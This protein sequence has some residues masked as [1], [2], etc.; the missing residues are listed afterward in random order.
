MA[1][2]KLFRS[3]YID[4][5]FRNIKNGDWG[6]YLAEE[7]KYDDSA[8]IPNIEMKVTPAKLRIPESGKSYDFENSK[9]IFEA[10]NNLTPVQATDTRLWTYLAHVTYWKYLK[11]RRPVENQSEEKRSKYILTHW[12]ID[13]V[14]AGS[15]LR[16]DISLLWWVSYLTHDSERT[17]P[18]ELTNEAFSMLDYTRHLLPGVQGRNKTFT[19]ALLEYV[20]ENKTLF[21]RYKEAKVRFLMRKANLIAGYKVFPSLSKE[22]IKSIFN[23]Y[24]SETESTTGEV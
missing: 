1:V 6:K 20:I 3:G 17:N 5:L 22:E 13:R 10:Y 2:Q 18:Y 23:S 24:R 9:N 21:E 8:V 15:F 11:V 14:S 12:F 16:Q 4:E 19:H 7:F